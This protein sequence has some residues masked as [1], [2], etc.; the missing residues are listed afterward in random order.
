MTSSPQALRAQP[1]PLEV[2]HGLLRP[3][4]ELSPAFC[5]ELN[6]RMRAERLTFGNRVHC[7]FLR[8]FFL[9]TQDEQRVREVAE[10]IARLGERVVRQALADPQLLAQVALNPHEERL[11]RIPPRYATSSTASRLDAFL[12]PDSLQF[13]EY[14]AESPAGLS[15]AEKLADIFEQLPVMK[16]F[17]ERYRV[18]KFALIRP[19]LDAQLASYREWGGTASPPTVA[20][21][22]WREVP[23]W[24]EFEILQANFQR[25]GVPTIVCDP[26][27]LEFDGKNLT[28]QSRRI[29]LLYRR[30]LINDI[31]AHPAEC[32]ALVN[33][34]AAGAVC[35]SNALTCKIAHKKAFFA[36]LTD[37]RNA[38]LFTP[39]ELDLIRRHIPWT[40]LLADTRTSRD[41]ESFG[42][43][44]YV[45]R[46]RSTFVLKPNDEYGGTGVTL[47]WETDDRA[48]DAALDRALADTGSA[49]VVQERINVRREVFPIQT[50][51]GVEMRDML[52]DFAP[53]IFRGRMAGF[54]TRLSSTGLANVT[55]GGGQ[56]P[57]FSVEPRD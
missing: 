41:A 54:L 40:R 18:R 20:I 10:A 2:W 26:R 21:V 1:S 37:D 22:D 48:W 24:S 46:R 23:T 3:D 9:T 29:D 36:V 31:V 47:G 28:A 57:A 38:A 44:D 8:P 34:Y 32:A 6:A 11:A 19:I 5:A 55:S 15:Y 7:P 49:W 30:V 27:D 45:R 35:V 13:A 52:V 12:L 16:R 43:L 17:A 39:A 50:E 51:T 25:E 33:A 56:V 53:Y 42:L 4:V 14:N